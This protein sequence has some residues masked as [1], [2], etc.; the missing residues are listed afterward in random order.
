MALVFII[1]L[2]VVFID[3]LTKFLVRDAL[4]YG[5]S[6]P[7]I[8]GFFNLVY[9]RNSGAAWG[10]FGDRT[11]FLIIFA[12]IVAI[13]MLVFR[14]KIFGEIKAKNVIMGL[15]LGG[16]IGNL[17]DRIRFTW[18]TDFLD[19]EFGTYHFPSFNVADMAICIAMGIYLFASWFSDKK[20]KNAEEKTD[21]T[22]E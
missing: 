7:V 2:V 19:F 11:H 17:I 1:S 5:E 10:M 12:I 21:A 20:S 4:Y 6:I 14:N 3:Q 9:V 8:D 16:I 22:N 15:L 13:L 18:V